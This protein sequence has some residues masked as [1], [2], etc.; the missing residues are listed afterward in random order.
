MT[1]SIATRRTWAVAA[2]ALAAAAAALLALRI[3]PGPAPAAAASHREAPLISLDPTADITDFFFF[4]SYEPGESDKVDLIM[5]VI[6]GE[7]PSSGPN[8][9]NFDPSVTYAFNVDNDRDGVADD[10]RFEFRFQNEIRGIVRDLKLPVSYFGGADG[11]PPITDFNS[12]GFGLRQR[13]TVTMFRHGDKKGRVLASG[14]FVAPSRVGPR[15]MPS[16]DSLAAQATYDLGDGI[17]VFA[18]QRDDPFYIDLGAAFDSLNFRRNPPGEMPAED[19]QDSVNP[20]GVDML[21]GF[22][23]H[24]IA[25]EVPTSL[26]TAD[27]KGADATAQPKLGAYAETERPKV[28]VLSG[29]NPEK[30]RHD[31]GAS[32]QVQRLANPLVNELIIGTVDKDLWNRLDPQDEARFEDYYLNP[33]FALALQLATGIPAEVAGRTDLRDLLLKYSPSD[34]QLSELLRLDVS[35]PPTPLPAQRRM[36]VLASPPDPAGWPNGRRPKDDVTD[37]ATRVVGGFNYVAARASDG[38]NTNDKPYPDHFPF[39]A[40]PHDG[41]DRHH[42]NP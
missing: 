11:V 39:L 25:L 20:Y 30:D 6:P 36:T 23:V 40:S 24:S 38:V 13:Y 34:T 12:P 4:R 16:Y 29:T 33:R 26:L 42:D 22:N 31:N 5:N 15:T 1:T 17:R 7:E 8:Y 27:G 14:L 18:G 35:V 2:L 10:V 28:E 41:R 37:I 19:A 32:V 9:W 21:A 3:A